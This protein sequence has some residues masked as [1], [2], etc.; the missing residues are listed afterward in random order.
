MELLAS[1]LSSGGQQNRKRG[2][3]AQEEKHLAL[4]KKDVRTVIETCVRLL[5]VLFLELQ[6]SFDIDNC[7]TSTEQKR[8]PAS[9]QSQEAFSSS[10][11]PRNSKQADAAVGT[12]GGRRPFAET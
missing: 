1:S 4:F 11:Q 3:L 8:Q 9:T 5:K 6:A 10:K 7:R 2:S 12:S